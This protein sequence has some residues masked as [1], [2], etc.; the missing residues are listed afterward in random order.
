MTDDTITEPDTRTRQGRHGANR[1]R[2]RRGLIIPKVALLAVL[3]LVLVVGLWAVLRDS[4]TD[5]AGPSCDQSTPL[6][7]VADPAI[8]PAIDT[9]LR[10]LRSSCVTVDLSSAPSGEIAA[11]L[12]RQSGWG[13]STKPPDVWIPDSR[14]WLDTARAAGTGPRELPRSGVSIATSPMVVALDPEKA[15]AAGWPSTPADWSQLAADGESTRSGTGDPRT[16]STALFGLFAAISGSDA[17]IESVARFGSRLSVSTGAVSPAQLVVD[18]VVDAIP[19]SEADVLQLQAGRGEGRVVA[20]YDPKMAAVLDFPATL[21]AGGDKEARGRAFE[22]LTTHLTRSDAALNAL[23]TV[24][25][26]SADGTLPRRFR[27]TEGV[28][29]AVAEP[30]EALTAAAVSQAQA[31][32]SLSGR[33]FRALLAIDRSGSMLDPLPGGTTSKAEIATR[34]IRRAVLGAS[35]DSDMG[36]RTFTT[37]GDAADDR[38]IVPV[39]RI[40]SGSGPENQRAQLLGALTQLAPIPAGDTPLYQA[41][42]SSYAQAQESFV[43]GRLNVVVIVTDGRNDHPAGELTLDRTIDQLRLQYDGSKPVRIVTIG[44][45]D[46]ADSAALK[47]IADVTGG[48]SYEGVTEAEVDRL[49]ATVLTEL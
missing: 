18:D 30:S 29:T 16:E 15:R 14:V 28:S 13:L 45:G 42:L 10:S 39:A 22:A 49:L 26:R 31:S 21:L 32:W 8:S 41:V 43:Y 11:A 46:G 34:S 40:S 6:R 19:T 5:D 1:R 17:D 7:V 47:R 12:G 37:D 25:L 3:A 9:A 27:D 24:G 36:L 38:E 35:P 20:S 33:R 4:G 2:G 44:Y 48:V 23:A